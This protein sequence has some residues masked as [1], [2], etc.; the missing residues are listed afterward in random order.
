MGKY[1]R[2]ITTREAVLRT[3]P[4]GWGCRREVV[5]VRVVVRQRLRRMVR[6]PGVLEGGSAVTNYPVYFELLLRWR[7]VL[8]L[9]VGF[10]VGWWYGG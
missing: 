2:R 4:V 9:G 5:A 7:Y 10:Y 8:A 6:E 3:W 1:V